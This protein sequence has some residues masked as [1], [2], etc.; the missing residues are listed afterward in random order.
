MYERLSIVVAGLMAAMLC[1]STSIADQDTT[2]A[3]TSWTTTAANPSADHRI[4]W[5]SVN[6]GGTD[7]SADGYVLHSSAGQAAVGTVTGDSY[8]LDQ[9]YWFGGEAAAACN[10]GVWGDVNGDGS[11]NPVDVIYIVSFVYKSLD[12]RTVWPECPRT[13]GDVNCDNSVNPLDMAYYV[14]YVYKSQ[15]AFCTDP[16]GP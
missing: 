11:I 9:G 10:C 14:Q 12:G 3:V 15:N 8:R 16:C 4:D 6:S 1:A 2:Q 13:T 5:W 7:L